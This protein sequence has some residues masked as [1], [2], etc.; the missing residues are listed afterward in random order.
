MNSSFALFEVL[1]TRTDPPPF[2]HTVWLIIILACYLGLAYLTKGTEGWYV[3]PFL[4]PSNGPVL[5]GY[6]VGI[7]AAAVIIFSVV[8]GI[9]RGRKW[10]TEVKLHKTGKL[11]SAGRDFEPSIELEDATMDKSSS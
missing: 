7:A 6:I 8:N 9:I 10:V 11:S 3:Y 5:A 1:L 2:V 4:N